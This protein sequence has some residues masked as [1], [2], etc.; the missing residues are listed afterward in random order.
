MVWNGTGNTF[1]RLSLN[2]CGHKCTRRCQLTE[3]S[4]WYTVL[5]NLGQIGHTQ[6]HPSH[7]LPDGLGYVQTERAAG[8]YSYTKQHSCKSRSLT[9]TVI[10]MF[11]S[12]TLYY[13]F[14]D[15]RFQQAT[16]FQLV[17]IGGKT[18]LL[19]LVYIV[20]V[21]IATLHIS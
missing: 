12:F 5:V 1:G 11:I 3:V 21:L 9:I 8:S 10:T 4:T 7:L 14:K 17:Y 6:W 16:D 18:F 19:V 15:I 13:N 2:T 20:H